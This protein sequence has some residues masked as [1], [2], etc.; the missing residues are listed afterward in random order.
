MILILLSMVTLCEEPALWFQSF[1]TK[2]LTANTIETQFP[3][4]KATCFSHASENLKFSAVREVANSGAYK[5][6]QKN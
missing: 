5:S 4:A 3:K 6:E 1:V 2:K